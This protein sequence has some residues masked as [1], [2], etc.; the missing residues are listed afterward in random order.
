[1]KIDVQ[2][3]ETMEARNTFIGICGLVSDSNPVVPV[4]P[5]RKQRSM[6]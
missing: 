5:D 1:M 2:P 6:L 4:S 3:Q